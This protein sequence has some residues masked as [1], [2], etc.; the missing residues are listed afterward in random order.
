MVEFQPSVRAKHIALGPDSKDKF[1][2]IFNDLA[3]D[4]NNP[5][6][7]YVSVTST[8]WKYYQIMWSFVDMHKEGLVLAVDIKTGKHH[9]V[10][11][12]IAFPN[13]LEISPNKRSLF[14]ATT[15]EHKV[16]KIDLA[17]ID[18]AIQSGKPVT[19][20]PALIEKLPGNPDNI[21]LF[22]NDLYIG[23]PIVSLNSTLSDSLSKLPLVRK[24][25]G[26]FANL[27]ARLL[28]QI[29]RLMPCPCTK[30]LASKFDNGYILHSLIPQN[31]GKYLS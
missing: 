19:K 3:L 30:E 11:D 28:Y 2:G 16:Y 29:D 9:I 24:S 10:L 6:R 18:A 26:R 22:G 23:L 27:I 4:P 14:V 15:G 20:K 13:G 12:D 8:K 1:I 17:D 21:R 7:V 31:S 25:F 5:D